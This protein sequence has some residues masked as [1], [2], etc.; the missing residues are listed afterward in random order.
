MPDDSYILLS[1]KLRSVASLIVTLG[2]IYV[3]DSPAV[4]AVILLPF[5]F[6]IFFPWCKAEV[7]MFVIASAFFLEQNYIVLTTGGF[8]FKYKNI[9]LMPYYEPF[10]WG[11]Y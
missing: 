4:V 11:F 10:M 7:L 5:W 2:I 9:L 6:F 8:T 3:V 1:Q